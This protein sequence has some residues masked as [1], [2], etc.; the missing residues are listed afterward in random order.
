MIKLLT[1][2]LSVCSAHLTNK[3]ELRRQYE[4][5]LR[6]HNKFEI[7]FGYE[8]F[9]Q[10]LQFIE[11]FNKNNPGCRMFLTQHADDKTSEKS[12]YNTCSKKN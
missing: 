9:V 5:F 6:F 4:G 12:L 7:P 2:F 11:D 1:L 8:T 10:N 3:Q